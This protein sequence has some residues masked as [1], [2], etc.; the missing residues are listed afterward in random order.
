[1]TFETPLNDPVVLSAAFI[2]QVDLILSSCMY[3][4]IRVGISDS[5]ELVR[6]FAKV[7]SYVK[8][9]KNDEVLNFLLRFKVRFGKC[10]YS[11]NDLY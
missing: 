8:Q 5:F 7:Q 3:V 6:I 4:P 2:S 9:I 1:M 10:K 11:I